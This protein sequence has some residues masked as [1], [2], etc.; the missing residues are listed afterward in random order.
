MNDPRF[1]RARMHPLAEAFQRPNGGPMV[2]SIGQGLPGPLTPQRAPGQGLGP[3]YEPQVPPIAP[4]LPADFAPDQLLRVR[5]FDVIAPDTSGTARSIEFPDDGWVIGMMAVARANG[6]E[7]GQ[8]GLQFQATVGENV[9]QLV[10]TGLDAT[11]ASFLAFGASDWTWQPLARRVSKLE[12]WN[13]T[14]RNVADENL[15][16]DITLKFRALRAPTMRA[17]QLLGPELAQ[18]LSQGAPL[19]LCETAPD[20]IVRVEGLTDVSPGQRSNTRTVQFP[21]DGYCTAILAAPGW[22]DSEFATFAE[23]RTSLAIQLQWGDTGGYFTTDGQAADFALLSC[24]GGSRAAWMPYFRA[25]SRTEKY[26]VSAFNFHPTAT[27]RPPEVLF[28]FRSWASLQP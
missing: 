16:P 26:A 19:V 1:D 17:P 2:P 12:R 23:A 10:T 25:V 3:G 21:E 13:F 7:A 5:A 11:W 15:Q 27:L 4:M 28:K 22:V 24:W 8:A 20:R 14:V 18:R 6:T 9:G